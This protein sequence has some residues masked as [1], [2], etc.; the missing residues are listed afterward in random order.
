MGFFLGYRRQPLQVPYP[1]C[2]EFHLR[3]L[4][5]IPGCFLHP[6]SLALLGIYPR[7]VPQYHRDTCSTVFIITLFIIARNRNWKTETEFSPS[8]EE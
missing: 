4:P 8:T 1:Y 7:D 5:L 3:S 2:C 6:R